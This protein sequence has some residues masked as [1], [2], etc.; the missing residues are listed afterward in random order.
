MTA[1]GISPDRLL[2]LSD[3]PDEPLT[4]APWIGGF[5]GLGSR[6]RRYLPTLE[7]RQLVLAVS[8]PRRDYAAALIGA[9]WMLSSPPPKLAEP[10]EVFREANSSKYL[11]G[12]TGQ[13]IVTGRFSK[14]LDSRP[15]AR[16]H[17]GGKLLQVERY[18][19]VAELDEEVLDTSEHVPQPGVLG[20]LSGASETWSERLASPPGDL[21][22]IGTEKWLREDLEAVIGDRSESNSDSTPLNTYVL[23]HRKDAATWSTPIVPPARLA[24]GKTLPD[25]CKAVILDRYGAI[26]YLN[27]ITVPIAVCVIDRSVADDSAAEMI[28]ELRL[29]NSQPVSVISDLG[30]RPPRAVEALAFTVAL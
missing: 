20:E 12:V 30:W 14:L 29:S 24:E 18:K 23:P 8:V 9:G 6:L 11:R 2:G 1:D 3:S 4:V 17:F 25:S 21:A 10:I 13:L 22:L 28:L 27:D 5:V 7:G 15:D 19:A 26:K 16:V